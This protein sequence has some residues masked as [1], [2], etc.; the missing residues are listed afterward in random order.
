MRHTVAKSVEFRGVGLHGGAPVRLVLRPAPAGHGIA[1]ER[2]DVSDGRDPVVPARYDLVAD[3]RLCTRLANA[4]GV[5]IGTV[6]HVMAALAGTGV[7][8]VR[9]A[10]DGPEIPIL[11]GSALPFVA[12][13]ARAGLTPLGRPAEAIRILRPVE[14]VREGKRARLD[15][16]PV[17]EIDFSIRFDDPAIGAQR[18][19]LALTG[20]A[21]ARELSDARTFC[22]LAEV[23]AMRAAGLARGGSLENAIVVDAGRVLNPGGLR[24]PDE[25]VRHKMLDAVGDLALAGAPI[26]GRYTGERAG[27]E[28]TSLL[29]HALFTATEAWDRVEATALPTL[30]GPG[31]LPRPAPEPALAI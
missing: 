18:H 9:L 6:E 2:T 1:F 12:A 31:A 21:F 10:L 20:D 19:R 28:M 15:Q 27:H 13:L 5:S 25:F 11:D 29:L 23:E 26:L 8:D 22:Y 30:P 3:T 7:T 14:V 17:P 24:R 4:D 16:A